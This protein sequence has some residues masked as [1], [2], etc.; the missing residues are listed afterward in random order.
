LEILPAKGS[1][2]SV[3]EQ[4]QD[5]ISRLE[6]ALMISERKAE[7]LSNMLKETVGEY[8]S[9]LDELRIARLTEEAL[10]RTNRELELFA[11]VV[12]HDLQAPLRTIAR[13][14]QLLQG[15]CDAQIDEEGHHFI[16]RSLGAAHRMQTLIEGLLSLARVKTAG[17]P[18]ESTDLNHIMKDVLENLH[19]LIQEKSACISIAW[20]PKLKGDPRQIQSLFQNL[21]LN[22]LRYNESPK[23]VI[24]IGCHEHAHAYQIFVKDNGIGISPKFHEDIFTVFHRLHRDQQYPGTGLGLALCKQIVERHGGTIGVESQPNEGATF[25]FTLLK[26]AG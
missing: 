25:H 7:V 4:L 12:S 21:I 26:D 13:F 6:Y 14:L 1:V 10:S 18:F 20:L 5:K 22:S 19:S 3:K 11:Y 8:E 2:V 24:E 23:P 17:K 16:E 15:R 9:S